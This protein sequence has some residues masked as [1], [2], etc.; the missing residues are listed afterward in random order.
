[1]THPR[2]HQPATTPA[3]QNAVVNGRAEIFIWDW[4]AQPP[5]D[6]I[7]AA[8]VSM[9]GPTVHVCA[10]DLSELADDYAYVVSDHPV[11]NTEA[12]ALLNEDYES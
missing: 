11:T 9:A 1:M 7:V 3:Q 6:R 4:K 12:R 5:I 8:A 2:N 10:R